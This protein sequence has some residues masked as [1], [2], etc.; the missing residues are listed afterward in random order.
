MP[1]K[2]YNLLYSLYRDVVAENQELKSRLYKSDKQGKWIKSDKPLLRCSVCG[3]YDTWGNY[4]RNC[5]SKMEN[6]IP[7]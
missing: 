3:Y 2:A 1:N 6:N 7:I 4:C 5:G